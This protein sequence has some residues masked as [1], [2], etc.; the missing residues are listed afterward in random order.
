MREGVLEGV[1]RVG[2]AG[3][4]AVQQPVIDQADTGRGPF[5]YGCGERQ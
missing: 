4:E 2:V 3:V 1:Q 5:P